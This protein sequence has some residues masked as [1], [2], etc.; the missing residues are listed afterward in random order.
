MST[1]MNGFVKSYLCS[2]L[3]SE[4]ENDKI[5]VTPEAWGILKCGT[6]RL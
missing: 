6:G 2:R 4:H 5:P 3:I 1:I